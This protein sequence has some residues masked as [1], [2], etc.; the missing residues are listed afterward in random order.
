MVLFLLILLCASELNA[1]AAELNSF[2]SELNAL[3]WAS[4]LASKV[5]REKSVERSL[6]QLRKKRQLD[7]APAEKCLF[8]TKKKRQL[9]LAP[10]GS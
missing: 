6:F 10:N 4:E 9:E 2:A 5:G 3:A 1:S 8:H 7:I